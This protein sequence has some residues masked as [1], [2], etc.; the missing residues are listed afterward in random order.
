MQD[1][2]KLKVW[3]R[4]QEACVRV[5]RL[6]AQYPLEDFADQLHLNAH[7]RARLSAEFA[8]WLVAHP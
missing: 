8:E 2:R 1:Y 3:H 4:A 5:Y 7:G 6:T